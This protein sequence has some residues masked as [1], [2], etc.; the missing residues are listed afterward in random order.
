[1]NADCGYCSACVHQV[2][3]P[4]EPSLQPPKAC[5]DPYTHLVRCSFSSARASLSQPSWQCRTSIAPIP[6]SPSPRLF[7]QHQNLAKCVLRLGWP[8][9]R[10]PLRVTGPCVHPW[11]G[12][13]Q[14]RH[15]AITAIC[16][17]WRAHCM[18]LF[19]SL[20]PSCPP[21]L[22]HPGDFPLMWSHGPS[23]NTPSA[24]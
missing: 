6:P 2:N 23:A 20:P 11:N 4:G 3:S 1:M 15:T 24:S 5:C 18:L 19:P 14:D 9:L 21:S 12:I 10:C 16:M 13:S 22:T 17:S 8:P 7:V